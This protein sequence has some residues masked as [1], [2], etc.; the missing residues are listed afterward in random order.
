MI[1]AIYIMLVDTVY[2]SQLYGYLTTGNVFC[3]V[4]VIPTDLLLVDTVFDSH[5]RR[6]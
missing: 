2:Q 3:C 4:M 1:I 6:Y 5:L